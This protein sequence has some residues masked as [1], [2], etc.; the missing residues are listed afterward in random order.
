LR[1]SLI[2]G[3]RGQGSNKQRYGKCADEPAIFAA[4]DFDFSV[5]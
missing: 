5:H 4:N 2:G 3:K 1:R